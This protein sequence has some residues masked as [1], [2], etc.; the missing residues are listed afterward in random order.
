VIDI[1]H[2]IKQTF[3][4]LETVTYFGVL[5]ELREEFQTDCNHISFHLDVFY[6][7]QS[8]CQAKKTDRHQLKLKLKKKWKNISNFIIF[9]KISF[10][11][12]H[13]SEFLYR[14]IIIVQIVDKYFQGWEKSFTLNDN[15]F[16]KRNEGEG[17][18]WNHG[19]PSKVRSYNTLYWDFYFFIILTEKFTLHWIST[20]QH[21]EKVKCWI[22]CLFLIYHSKPVK[23][24]NNVW[25]HH[26]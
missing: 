2:S 6:E 4:C 7:E 20:Q 19:S 12:R 24:V 3:Q 8:V 23:I 11:Q 25:K 21:C 15:Y 13:W 22:V 10:R 9:H 16:L 14:L 18:M 26:W 17:K 5:F 1:L